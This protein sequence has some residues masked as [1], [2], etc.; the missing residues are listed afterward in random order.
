MRQLSLFQKLLLSNQRGGPGVMQG[1]I[2]ADPS[3]FGLLATGIFHW[4]LP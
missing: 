4:R 1:T 2:F 3:S